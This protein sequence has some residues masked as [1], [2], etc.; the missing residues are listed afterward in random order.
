MFQQSSTYKS[1]SDFSAE[2]LRTKRREFERLLREKL[3]DEIA[4]QCC[5]Y[6][7]KHC[8]QLLV[9]TEEEV[10]QFFYEL[11]KKKVLNICLGTILV[12][13]GAAVTLA[14][15]ITE[16]SQLL[17]PG[18]VLLENGK[19]KFFE[20]VDDTFTRSNTISSFPTSSIDLQ[21]YC[22]GKLTITLNP[23]F[24]KLVYR[25]QTKLQENI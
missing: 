18:F 9:Q 13:G 10:A 19:N 7:E 22:S 12:I 5:E 23:C 1:T 17:Q 11:R 3:S 21:K 16:N 24:G 4:D 20:K 2:D 14:G 6:F 8:D 15:L 25:L